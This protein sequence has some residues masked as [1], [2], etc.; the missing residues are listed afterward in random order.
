MTDSNQTPREDFQGDD[1]GD[2]V[3]SGDV[4]VGDRVD[5]SPDVFHPSEVVT[6]SEVR[7][8]SHPGVNVVTWNG[9]RTNPVNRRVWRQRRG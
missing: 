7:H 9:F 1:C 6:V 4:R 2:W 3:D 5:V 8:P